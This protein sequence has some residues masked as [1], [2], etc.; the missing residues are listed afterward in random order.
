MCETYLRGTTSIFFVVVFFPFS[1]LASHTVSQERYP[2][3]SMYPL[4]FLGTMESPWSV[5][6]VQAPILHHMLMCSHPQHRTHRQCERRR[7][8]A[9][10]LPLFTAVIDSGSCTLTLVLGLLCCLCVVLTAAAHKPVEQNRG[11]HKVQIPS[12]LQRGHR[13]LKSGSAARG[14]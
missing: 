1:V 9:K 11:T 7:T 12:G 13:L 10:P 6:F 5:H 3:S 2:T 8:K 4:C 14:K